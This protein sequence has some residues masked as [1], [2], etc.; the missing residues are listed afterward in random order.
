MSAQLRACSAKP[1]RALRARSTNMATAGTSLHTATLAS[2]GGSGSGST[3]STASPSRSSRRR[4][5]TTRCSPG[6]ACNQP[7]STAAPPGSTSCSKLSSTSSARRPLRNCC[8][9]A[10]SA[11]VTPNG[12]CA[13]TRFGRSLATWQSA[14]G[15]KA[16]TSNCAA[17]SRVASTA[18]RVLPAPPGPCSVIRRWL[19]SASCKRLRSAS[20]PKK[21]LANA[22]IWVQRSGRH[23]CCEVSCAIARGR[24]A[25]RRFGAAVTTTLAGSGACA[26]ALS[27]SV[28]RRW[29]SS[30]T[31]SS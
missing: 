8:I 4:E 30:S 27:A 28:A 17:S 1:G 21:R 7:A 19:A 12:N 3:G 31:H 9:A 22:G 25:V 11:P 13:A 20:R 14:S 16:I 15:T 5:V 10:V 18:R 23:D 29:R 6:R 26:A 2:T 24:F